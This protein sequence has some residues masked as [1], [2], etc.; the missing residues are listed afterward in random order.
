MDQTSSTAD[1][2]RYEII[3]V[4]LSNGH[5]IPVQLD[6]QTGETWQGHLV[7]GNLSWRKISVHEDSSFMNNASAGRRGDSYR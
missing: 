1:I 2:S 4:T 7:G 3:I 6:K 5:I